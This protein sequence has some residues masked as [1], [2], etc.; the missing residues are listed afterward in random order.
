MVFLKTGRLG[1]GPRPE[2]RDTERIFLPGFNGLLFA[3][4]GDDC[5]KLG[6]GKKSG[7]VCQAPV[8]KHV[9]LPPYDLGY[10]KEEEVPP[11]KS[12]PAKPKKSTKGP[13]CKQEG[14]QKKGTCRK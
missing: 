12:C 13:C 5:K 11:L 6:K 8:V 3:S 7:T 14:G 10:C 4:K 2:A 9:P 1:L